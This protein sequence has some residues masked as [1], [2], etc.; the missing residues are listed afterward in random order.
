MI[1]IWSPEGS[2]KGPGRVLEPKGAPGG[3]RGAKMTPKSLQND[4]KVMPKSVKFEG[5]RFTRWDVF[6]L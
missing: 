3:P 6:C 5:K 1:M 4:P 2:W